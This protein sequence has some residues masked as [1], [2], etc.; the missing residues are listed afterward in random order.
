MRT[1]IKIYGPPHMP[2]LKALEKI[3]ADT[4]QICVGDNCDRIVKA[5]EKIG[6]YDFYF[7]W[8]KSPTR[9]QLNGLLEMIDGA[10]AVCGCQYTQATK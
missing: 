2:A 3:A 9:E 8:H 5:G 6:D 10:M 1:Y 7:E 4:H